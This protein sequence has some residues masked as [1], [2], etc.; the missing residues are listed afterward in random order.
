MSSLMLKA[1][2]EASTG[3]IDRGNPALL[4]THRHSPEALCIVTLP[5]EKE[6]F[7]AKER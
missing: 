5:L 4:V 7:N 1:S 3:E 6:K 2:P